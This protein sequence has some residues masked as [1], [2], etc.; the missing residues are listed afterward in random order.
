VPVLPSWV[1]E[2]LWDRF[3]ALLPDRDR[4]NPDHPLGCHRPRIADRIVG[5]A[6]NGISVDGCIN[7]APDITGT[8][9]MTMQLAKKLFD[10]YTPW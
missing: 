4:Q 7:K 6:L 10:E 2:P 3:P 5:S 1:V 8:N 9:W